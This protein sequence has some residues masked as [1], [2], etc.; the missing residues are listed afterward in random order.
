[1]RPITSSA[2]SGWRNSLPKKP[3]IWSAAVLATLT[4]LAFFGLAPLVK[5]L[6]TK[7]LSATL[8]RDVSSQKVRIN[9]FTLSVTITGLLIQDRET[10][11]SFVSL[12]EIFLNLERSSALGRS[13]ILKEV[14]LSDPSI[15]IVRD[16]DHS[17][18]FSDL[19]ATD[20]SKES[21]PAGPPLFSLN[22]IQIVD[23]SVDFRIS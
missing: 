16:Q 15:R 18:N 8:H 23:G 6:L 1:M 5:S 14:R 11:E 3:L 21:S 4:I 12:S 9:P 7:S 2:P 19:L 13:L 22:S 20:P 17:Y 10:L